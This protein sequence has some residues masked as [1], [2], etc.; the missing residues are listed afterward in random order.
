MA[1]LGWLSNLDFAASA[2]DTP[3]T[4]PADEPY[5]KP[6]GRI[7]RRRYLV[8]IDDRTFEVESPEHAYSLLERAAEM[9]RAHAKTIVAPIA[10]RR[11]AT[12][13]PVPTPT[14]AISADA[15]ELSEIVRE[16]RKRITD[17]YRKALV[18]EEIRL[19]LESKLKEEDDDDD[20]LLLL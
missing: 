2:S 6:A 19:R 4:P 8:E 14:P 3:I 9:A 15:P 17:I 18:E 16:A 1:A 5:P 12:N 11:V 10:Q 20:I 13:R 7:R